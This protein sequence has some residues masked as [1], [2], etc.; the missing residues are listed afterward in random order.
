MPAERAPMRK[1]REALRL[2][3]ALDLSERLVAMSVGVSRS[4][5]A[6]YLPLRARHQPHL[7]GSRYPL[8]YGD[9]AYSTKEATRQGQGRGRRSHHR[10]LRAGALAQP[11]PLLAVR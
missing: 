7:P 8:R 5:V 11:G 10:A 4:T 9:P 1:I 2:K 6:E 3:H